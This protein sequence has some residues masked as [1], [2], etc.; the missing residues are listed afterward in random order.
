MLTLGAKAAQDKADAERRA[1]NAPDPPV[2]EGVRMV[3][4]HRYAGVP[5]RGDYVSCKSCG[6]TK[7]IAQLNMAGKCAYTPEYAEGNQIVWVAH[8]KGHRLMRDYGEPYSASCKHCG[9]QFRGLPRKEC[10]AALFE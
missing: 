2:E 7:Q 9:K 3:K 5:G 4:G 8:V 6:S 1:R 10:Q